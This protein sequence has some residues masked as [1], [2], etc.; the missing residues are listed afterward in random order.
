MGE[1]TRLTPSCP[2]RMHIA[3]MDLAAQSSADV[4]ASLRSVAAG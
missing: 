3:S 4:E 1:T 2:N